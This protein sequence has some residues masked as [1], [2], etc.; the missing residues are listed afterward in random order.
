MDDHFT[1]SNSELLMCISCLDLEIHWLILIGSNDFSNTD[2]FELKAQLN[3]YISYMRSSDG[4]AFS[5]LSDI[6]DLAKKMVET[7]SQKFFN[8]VYRLIEFALV[9]P[10]ATVINDLRNRMGDEFLNNSLVCYVEQEAFMSIE[11]ENILQRFQNMQTRK[12]KLQ[13]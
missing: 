11:N 9:L 13:C 4:T 10:V 7:K 3:T 12:I 2:K 8:L 1:K 6:G 5:G